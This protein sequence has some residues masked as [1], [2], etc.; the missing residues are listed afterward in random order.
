[1]HIMTTQYAEWIGFPGAG[2]R[3]VLLVVAGLT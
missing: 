2:H 1:M 3:D